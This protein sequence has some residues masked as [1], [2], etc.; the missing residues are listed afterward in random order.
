MGIMKLGDLAENQ[1]L[2]IEVIAKTGHIEYDVVSKFSAHGAVFIEPIRYHE[3]IINFV[4][5]DIIINVLYT[6]N[7]CKPIEWHGCY[8]KWVEYKGKQYHMIGCKDVGMEVNRR[9]CFRIFVGEE[10]LAQVGEHTGIMKVTVKDMSA[11]GFSFLG[12]RELETPL[13]GEVRLTFEDD[14]RDIRFDLSGRLVRK[15]KDEDEKTLYGC[16]LHISNKV[17]DSYI[18]RRQREQAQHLQKHLAGRFKSTFEKI[19]DSD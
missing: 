16:K 17:V 11:T 2:H 5:S 4:R 1:K 8:I 15:A 6:R 3:Q 18:A 13:G 9:G 12:E 10:G 14:I 7:S 19:E